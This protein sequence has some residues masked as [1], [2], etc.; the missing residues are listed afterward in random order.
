MLSEFGGGD[1]DA[2]PQTLNCGGMQPKI[3]DLEVEGI[4]PP[5]YSVVDALLA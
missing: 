2:I 3:W 1:K 4:H 5:I